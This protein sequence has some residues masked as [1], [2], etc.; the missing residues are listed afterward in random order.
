MGGL[1][2]LYAMFTRPHLVGGVAALS[3]SLWVH[4]FAILDEARRADL[5][6]ARIYVDYGTREQSALPMQRILLERG[7]VEG[8][9]LHFVRETGGQHNEA[10]WARRLP[11]ALRYLLATTLVE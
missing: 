10:A 11:N 4:R 1:I 2:S 9:Q 8:E 3:P 6:R 5:S 7:L